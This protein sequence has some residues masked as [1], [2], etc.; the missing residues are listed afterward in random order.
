M[1][2]K[3]L[4]AIA[5]ALLVAVLA[6]DATA[7][8][9]ARR[10]QE[11]F[12]PAVQQPAQP[13]MQQP[14]AK[15]IVSESQL[16]NDAGVCTFVVFTSSNW[17]YLPKELKLLQNIKSNAK[18]KHITGQLKSSWFDPN[19]K[20][21]ERFYPY[22][23]SVMPVV[24]VQEPS[25]E[26]IYKATGTAVP[27]DGDKLAS[28][29]TVAIKRHFAAGRVTVHAQQ[30]LVYN[31]ALVSNGDAG[32]P[33]RPRPQPEPQPS[34]CPLRPGPHIGPQITVETVVP[35]VTPR[36]YEE[37]EDEEPQQPWWL[38]AVLVVVGVAVGVG[39]NVRKKVGS[40]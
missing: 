29:I 18:I 28:D 6:I 10:W 16:P 38:L 17:E 23:G 13:V 34:P 21:F 8:P 3:M 22:I 2:M 35:D 19:D 11:P 27:D 39:I 31:T 14:Q 12:Q 32:R 15:A 5:F 26:I 30:P 9:F 7:G 4:F 24:M 1:K 36:D 20:E 33:L 40:V 37:S 25:G